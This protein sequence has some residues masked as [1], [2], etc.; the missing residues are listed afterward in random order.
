MRRI[1]S[2]DEIVP[3]FNRDGCI[4]IYW[5]KLYASTAAFVTGTQRLHSVQP[6]TQRLARVASAA[7]SV[8][9]RPRFVLLLLSGGRR[10]RHPFRIYKRPPLLRNRA[11]VRVSVVLS[12]AKPA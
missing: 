10:S 2:E 5:Y 3:S 7:S 1:L 8:A 4:Y 9:E 11:K 6:K 12:M